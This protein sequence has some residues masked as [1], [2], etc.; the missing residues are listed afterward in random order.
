MIIDKDTGKV[1][2][3]RKEAHVAHVTRK[4]DKLNAENANNTTTIKVGSPENTST[5]TSSPDLTRIPS[6]SSHT[7]AWGDWWKQ[8]RQNNQDYLI[9]A[10]N[11]HLDEVIKLL[12]VAALH[13]KAADINVKGIDQWTALHFAANEGRVNVVKELI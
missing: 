1:Y 8:K 3:T 2:D 4:V 6:G 13:E 9:A 5:S 12:D 11:G 10:E 7:K